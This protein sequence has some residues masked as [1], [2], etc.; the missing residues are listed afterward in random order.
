[1]FMFWGRFD[2]DESR[3][4]RS[5]STS[6]RKKLCLFIRGQWERQKYVR[7]RSS[8]IFNRN[9]LPRQWKALKAKRTGRPSLTFR[10]IGTDS[11]WPTYIVAVYGSLECRI[12]YTTIKMFVLF[13]SSS[14]AA[15]KLI[16]RK[17]SFRFL[18]MKDKTD[19]KIKNLIWKVKFPSLTRI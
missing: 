2:D 4:D 9:C 10:D 3:L 6:V 11:V 1:M 7:K 19:R 5:S 16:R 18:L 15:C 12:K 13:L 8:F 14:T 17:P